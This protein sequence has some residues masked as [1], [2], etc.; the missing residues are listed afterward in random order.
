MPTDDL[1]QPCH[2]CD[3]PQGPKRADGT[4]LSCG[5]AKFFRIGLTAG[6]VDGLVA[7]ARRFYRADG[8]YEEL[9]SERAV[10]ERRKAAAGEIERLTAEVARLRA[11]LKSIHSLAGD[12]DNRL[13]RDMLTIEA[14]ARAALS[15]E[16]QMIGKIRVTSS[17][18]DPALGKQVKDPTLGLAP[19]AVESVEKALEC[20][21]HQ[22]SKGWKKAETTKIGRMKQEACGHRV[23]AV[24]LVTDIYD[25]YKCVIEA[26]YSAEQIAREV[27]RGSGLTTGN[28]CVGVPLG[29]VEILDIEADARAA[30]EPEKESPSHAT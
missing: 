8:T 10:V 5:G 30:L 16:T 23:G 21:A 11:V 7:R 27:A 17:G 24:V 1:Y 18:Y 14:D 29:F 3:E 13:C 20:L 9:H 4:C 19:E 22:R 2:W 12:P 15:E 28:P 6:Q 25:G 26:P